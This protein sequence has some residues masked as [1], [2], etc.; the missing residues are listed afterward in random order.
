MVFAGTSI[1]QGYASAVVTSTGMLTE[2]GKIQESI[3]EAV[4]ESSD[5]PLK[6]KLDRFAQQLTWVRQRYFLS[7]LTSPAG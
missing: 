4:N 1:S 6:L 2:I 7:S 5:T 3:T